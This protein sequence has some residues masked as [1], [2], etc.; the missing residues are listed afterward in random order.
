[1][2]LRISY[3]IFN[4]EQGGLQPSAAP[5]TASDLYAPGIAWSDFIDEL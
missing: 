3:K 1:M 2:R 5:G 4:A